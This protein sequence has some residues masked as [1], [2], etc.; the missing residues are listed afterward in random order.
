LQNEQKPSF[1]QALGGNPF[2][3]SL[4]LLDPRQK[5]SG[6]TFILQEALLFVIFFPD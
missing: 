3:N 2:C 5:H 6:V 1:P 4:K